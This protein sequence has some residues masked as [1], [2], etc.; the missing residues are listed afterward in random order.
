ME[1]LRY[2]RE[3]AQWDNWVKDLRTELYQ[4]LYQEP[5]YP[6]NL[7]AEHA[8]MKHDQYRRE[9]IDRQIALMLRRGIWKKSAY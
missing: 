2:H 3:R 5:I 9:V 4:L 6:K 1:A 8:P 7:Y